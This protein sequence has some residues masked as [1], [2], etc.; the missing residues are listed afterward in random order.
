GRR[1][2]ETRSPTWATNPRGEP[3]APPTYPDSLWPCPRPEKT[4]RA[5]G[6][7]ARPAGSWSMG[8]LMTTDAS[9][10]DDLLRR[11]QAGDGAALAALFDLYRDRLKRMIRLR[12]DR[13]LSGRVDDSDVLQEAYLDVHRRF[14]EYAAM[15]ESWP[16]FL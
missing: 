3:P 2:V 1:D 5:C 8:T 14:P 9:E 13:R 4:A 10:T 11:A 16:F 12:L 7:P 15:A 6:R